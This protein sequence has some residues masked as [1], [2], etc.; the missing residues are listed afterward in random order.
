MQSIVDCTDAETR[1]DFKYMFMGCKT[2][3]EFLHLWAK[4]Y[5][6]Q[7][8]IP[9]YYANFINLDDDDRQASYQLGQK[10]KKI[11][12]KGIICMDSQDTKPYEQKGYIDALVPNAIIR[13]LT[14]YLNRYNNIVA[15][16]YD[17]S[18]YKVG[19]PSL[20]DLIVTFDSSHKD[21]MLNQE[22]RFPTGDAFTHVGNMYNQ[23][24]H[25]DP[26]LNNQMKK[27]INTSTYSQL[28]I[29]NPSYDSNPEYIIDVLLDA[30]NT[31]I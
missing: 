24:Y 18:K 14:S 28:T 26:W 11:T 25:I 23:I 29:I 22:M 10:F 4:F 21:R 16:N 5:A 3:D 6:N 7:A 31:I 9:S 15:F 30:V 20:R 1:L 17:L 19:I 13:A 27:I 2:I 8:C 12:L